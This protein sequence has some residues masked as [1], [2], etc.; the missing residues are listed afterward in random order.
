MLESFNHI[1][2]FTYKKL[3]PEEQKSRGI[4]GRLEGVIADGKNPTRNGRK[5]PLALWEKV[6]ENPIMKEKIENKVCLGELGHPEGRQ[7]T[8]ITKAALCLAEFPKKSDDGVIYGVF[9][10]I[11]TPCGRILKTLCDYGCNIGVSSRGS[12]DTYEDYDG[13]EVVDEDT[14]ECECWDAVLLPA[15][16]TA[17]LNYVNESIGN[18]T[19]YKTLNEE[20]NSA[21]TPK[22]RATMEECLGRIG[23]DYKESSDE[24]ISDVQDDD[25]NK[26]ND[27]AD[28]AGE[29][30]LKS[31]QEAL[32]ENAAL[33]KRVTK[34]QEKLSVCYAKDVKNEVVVTKLKNAVVKLSENAKKYSAVKNQL[35]SMK[36]QLETKDDEVIELKNLNESLNKRF[37]KLRTSCKT[38][39]NNI[40]TKDE[41]IVSLTEELG[42][43]K[44]QVN[45]AMSKDKKEVIS[46]KEEL[47]ELRRDS[48]AKN[49]QYK[50]NLKKA[51]K[52]VEKYRK[53]SEEA[54]KRY[55]ENKASQLGV[56]D[57]E[58][59]N[60]LKESY[61][62]D[63]I[64]KVCDELRNYKMNMSK[65]PFN[66]GV[67]DG[68]RIV[69]TESKK[70]KRYENPDDVLDED[71]LKLLN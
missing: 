39:N 44:K 10:I 36:E 30:L 45:E 12:G 28:N 58:I 35:V 38:L 14:Y 8:D 70:T 68:S 33:T 27:E 64:D 67:T 6:F 13:T 56:S 65:L 54:V 47:N 69:M 26:H 61:S 15:V 24:T 22:I 51:D 1:N 29:D 40:D 5:Y 63:D 7:E 34:L 46:L 3:T 57:V 9:D 21:E 25:V 49:T 62:F 53:S 52:L 50:N 48:Q 42:K 4:L 20:L 60:K 17:R 41:K 55:I 37:E 11:N 59:K 43:S 16:E 31:L 19:L 2:K 23:L 71:L 32:K 66:F 18:K